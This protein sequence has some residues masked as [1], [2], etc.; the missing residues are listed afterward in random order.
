MRLGSSTSSDLRR[1][2]W[3]LG[4][5]GNQFVVNWPR[6]EENQWASKVRSCMVRVTQCRTRE[7][8]G[9]RQNPLTT[10]TI[11]STMLTRGA[12]MS[13][14]AFHRTRGPHDG[15][16]RM[17]RNEECE[18]YVED[19]K[20]ARECCCAAPDAELPKSDFFVQRHR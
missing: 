16:A 9:H 1:K 3:V 14:S 15:H 13:A 19:R 2:P 18:K 20:S 10:E 8:E 6:S 11:G 7:R 17:N 4:Y 5:Q 12:A